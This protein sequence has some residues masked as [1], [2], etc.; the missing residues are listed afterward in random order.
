MVIPSIDRVA[1]TS[2]FAATSITT[3]SWLSETTAAWI[4]ASLETVRINIV[5]AKVYEGKLLGIFVMDGTRV[6]KELGNGVIDGTELGNGVE[7]GSEVTVGCG[8]TIT[9]KL[10]QE[11]LQISSA[12]PLI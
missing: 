4:S 1:E 3:P 2:I 5:G 10:P 9:V 6:G 8:V 11:A 7:V 12:P